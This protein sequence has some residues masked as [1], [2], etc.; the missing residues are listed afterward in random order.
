MKKYFRIVTKGQ[1]GMT[2]MVPNVTEQALINYVTNVV[3]D[4]YVITD[5]FFIRYDQI[6]FIVCVEMTT[7]DN[8]QPFKPTIVS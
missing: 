7:P 5:A 1:P 8:V 6:K 3:T 2:F 4:G